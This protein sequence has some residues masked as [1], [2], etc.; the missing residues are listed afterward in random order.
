MAATALFELDRVGLEVD[1]HRILCDVSLTVPDGGITVLLG[2]SGA[3]KT[4]ILRLLNRLEVPTS[5]EVRLLGQPIDELDPLRLRRRVGM[6]FQRPVVFPGTARDN[7]LTAHSGATDD[8]LAPRLRE[9]GLDTDVLDQVA[10]DLSGGEAQRLCLARTLATDPEILLMD[11]PTSSLDPEARRRL[12]ATSR[13]LVS[14]GMRMVWV[15]HDLA[16]ADR[17]ADH[18]VV[19]VDGRLATEAETARYLADGSVADGRL[20]DGNVDHGSVDDRSVDHGSGAA[21][22]GGGDA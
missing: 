2:P 6:V 5:G 13:A 21:D 22:E 4:T 17:L 9:A 8:E 15:T 10:D 19:I 20:A 14:E 11:E 3:G 16:Q 7:L 1:G 18:R 12:E